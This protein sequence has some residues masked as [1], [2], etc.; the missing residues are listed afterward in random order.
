MPWV[1]TK[2][3]FDRLPFTRGGRAKSMSGPQDQTPMVFWRGTTDGFG[4]HVRGAVLDLGLH[5]PDLVNS[6]VSD[7]Y[8][9]L[10]RDS[11]VLPPHLKDMPPYKQHL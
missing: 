7:W 11:V 3:I 10:T 4:G 1:A 8:H 2:D 6:G 9:H 5:R